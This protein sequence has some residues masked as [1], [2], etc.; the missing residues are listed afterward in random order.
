MI[1]DLPESETRDVV[2]IGG[3]PAGSVAG[4]YLAR[5]GMRPLLLE[6]EKFPRFV[7]GESLLPYGNDIL[8]ELGVWPELEKAGFIKKYGA[9]FST[10]FTE[11]FNRY[12]F[13]QALDAGYE[14]TFQVDRAAFDDI[15]LR[16]A[17]RAGCEVVESAHVTALAHCAKDKISLSYDGP[18]GRTSLTAS[19]LV[20]ASGRTGIVGRF[21]DIPKY[22]T[23][24]RKMVAIYSHFQGVHRN[25]G[26]AAGHTVIVRFKSGWSW[27]IPLADGKT[28][29]GIVIP[30]DTLREAQGDLKS[31]FDH[32]VSSHPDLAERMSRAEGL[33]PLR[34]TADY[35]WRFK[36]FASGRVLLTGDAAGFV[37]PIFSS[38]VMLAM[39]SARLAANTILA[40]R[41]R[42][43]GLDS[44]ECRQ[45]TAEVA[46][47]MHL[48]SR[49]IRSFYERAGF[50]IF[51]HPL[52]YF[53]IPRSI[54][55]L[56]GGRMDLPAAQ[57]LRLAAF[58]LLCALQR[59]F[60]LAPPIR[61]LR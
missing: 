38:G 21:L 42:Q 12:W 15:L 35:S 53:K 51:M 8:K 26:D 7:I 19:W 55:Y 58:S 2:I 5:A 23:R 50:E 59:F 43:T 49:I 52:P 13:R 48:Y 1:S 3:G 10:G 40:A 36:S 46:G 33:M 56:V 29:V 6:K 4:A 60:N 25:S 14:H 45:Y 28:S 31:V 24:Q 9:D 37:D 27:L 41:N 44:G 30:A 32:H 34:A 16:N 47:W 22:P 61:S 57:R 18:N 11:R 20:D 39:K 54:G 17:R